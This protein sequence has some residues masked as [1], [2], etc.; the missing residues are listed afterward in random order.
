MAGAEY[1][2]WVEKEEARHRQLM[3]DAGFLSGD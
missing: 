2:A 3:Q 1:A